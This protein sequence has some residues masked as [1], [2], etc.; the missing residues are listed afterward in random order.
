MLQMVRGAICFFNA[1]QFKIGILF[2][3]KENL[4]PYGCR[5]PNS[6]KWSFWVKITTFEKRISTFFVTLHFFK[7]FLGFK[8]FMPRRNQYLSGFQK[9]NFWGHTFWSLFAPSKTRK[10][11]KKWPK[12]A[13]FRPR[14][15][16][17]VS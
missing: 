5:D 15:A 16:V 17:T 14:F 6:E 13:V 12:I 1:N 2:L 3:K 8:V 9:M 10:M 7:P 11:A 4:R